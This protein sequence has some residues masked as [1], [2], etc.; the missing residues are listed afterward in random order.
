M[1]LVFV[2]WIAYLETYPEEEPFS[3]TDGVSIWP[4]E[5]LR[6]IA[7]CLSLFF[8]FK[9]RADSVRNIDELTKSFP[10]FAV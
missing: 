2:C 3:W 1:A 4:T 9:A 7:M 6:F 8:L 10:R 5:A